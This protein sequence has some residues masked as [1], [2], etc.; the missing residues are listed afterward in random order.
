MVVLA[1]AMVVVLAVSLLHATGARA[2]LRTFNSVGVT[3]NGQGYVPIGTDGAVYAYGSTAYHGNPTGFTGGIVGIAVTADGQGYVAISSAGQVYAY[4]TVAYRGNP[5][6]FSGSI[7]GIAVTGDGQ[8]YIAMSSYGQTYAYGTVVSRGNPSGFDYPMTGISVTADGQGYAAVSHTGQVYAYGTVAYRGNPSGFTGSIASISTTANGQGYIAVSTIGQTYAY[9]AV[10]SRGNPTGFTGS[11]VAVSTTADGQGY[12]VLSSTGQVYAYG[13]VAYWGNGDPGS[14][15]T[16]ALRN[17]VTTLANNE[18]NNPS[19]NVEQGN[20]S[21]SDDCNYYSTSLRAGSTG[22]CSNGWLSED[23]CADFARWVWQQSGAN[24]SGLGGGAIT[25]K[26]R[27]GSNW[28]NDLTNVQV[29][30]VIGWR[31]GTAATSDDHVSIVVA[32]TST[33]LTVIEGNVGSYPSH[34]LQNTYARTVNNSGGISG[35]ATL[36]L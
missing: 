21:T 24:V 28:H 26:N 9:G 30:D 23:W 25:F 22:R 10:V 6:G 1:M 12:A 8:G 7:V 27:T 35:Y 31:F 16:N 32:V 18:K 15:D 13:T 5:T 33:T 3:A 2:A 36:S 34:V 17:A 29:G 11:I 4:G 14:N 20:M 19:H